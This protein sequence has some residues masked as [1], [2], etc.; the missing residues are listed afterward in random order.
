MDLSNFITLTHTSVR[1][2]RPLWTEDVLPIGAALGVVHRVAAVAVHAL[3]AEDALHGQGA[4]RQPGP[5]GE[6]VRGRAER[7]GRR[8]GG[9]GHWK[10]GINGACTAD[11]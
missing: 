2:T 1:P 4:T 3:G 7:V 10:G 6:G 8:T 5:V 9:G 11:T